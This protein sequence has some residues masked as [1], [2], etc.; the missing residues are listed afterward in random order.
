MVYSAHKTYS[1]GSYF[2]SSCAHDVFH[3]IFSCKVFEYVIGRDWK[4]TLAELH[5][6]YSLNTK[7]MFAP[8]IV[9]L[10]N[11]RK[12]DRYCREKIRFYEPIYKSM[13]HCY[14]FW[15]GISI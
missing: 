10:M 4:L 7:W 3:V 14:V 8:E 6:E 13:L 11:G 2:H 12:K 5:L 1:S 9:N 15:S